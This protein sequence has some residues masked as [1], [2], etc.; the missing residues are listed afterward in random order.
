MMVAQ[1]AGQIPPIYTDAQEIMA[2]L[3]RVRISILEDNTATQSQSKTCR[4]SAQGPI[5]T[6]PRVQSDLLNCWVPLAL[7]PVMAFTLL[8]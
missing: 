3:A 5:V 2:S 6:F 7:Q 4:Q 1:M 8:C